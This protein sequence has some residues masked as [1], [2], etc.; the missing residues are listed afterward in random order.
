M[1]KYFIPF[2]GARKWRY[3]SNHGGRSIHNY[4][5]K[6]H[7]HCLT[8]DL[9][10]S[11]KP[12]CRLFLI[13]AGVLLLFFFFSFDLNYLSFFSLFFFSIARGNIC[14][15]WWDH[16]FIICLICSFLANS[17]CYYWKNLYH[18]FWV[19]VVLNGKDRV[20][21]AR[22]NPNGFAKWKLET[23]D[24]IHGFRFEIYWV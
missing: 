21:L 2:D 16:P 11:F 20:E 18:G 5:W 14:N 13:S 4:S 19:A 8:P 15:A 12:K 6:Q 10:W 7:Y 23:L 22:L 9:L 24:A 1:D 17:Y 3:S